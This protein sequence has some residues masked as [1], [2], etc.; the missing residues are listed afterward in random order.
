LFNIY[1]IS[2]AKVNGDKTIYRCKSIYKLSLLGRYTLL[3]VY[4]LK[5]LN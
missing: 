2:K 1:I 3:I 5:R 4:F